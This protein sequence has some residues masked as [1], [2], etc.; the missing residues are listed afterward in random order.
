MMLG[1]VLEPV[2]TRYSARLFGNILP[3]IALKIF[4]IRQYACKFLPC[5]QQNLV[6]NPYTDL[7]K[8]GS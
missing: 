6:K 7:V 3:L 4:V 5:H 2:F 8:T 1:N